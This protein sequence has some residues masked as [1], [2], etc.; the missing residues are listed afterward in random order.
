[1]IAGFHH[2]VLFCADTDDSR[3]WFERV[4]FVYKRGFGGMQW[5]ALGDGERTPES[6]TRA[7]STHPT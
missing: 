2:I 3:D 5:F 7:T 4:G 1:M 6:S